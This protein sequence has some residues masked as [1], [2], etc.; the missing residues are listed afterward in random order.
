M[1]SPVPPTTVIPNE[2]GRKAF[3]ALLGGGAGG[4]ALQLSRTSHPFPVEFFL[5]AVVFSGLLLVTSLTLWVAEEIIFPPGEP[6][7]AEQPSDQPLFLR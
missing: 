5:G 2:Y 6:A 4:A 7:E 3:R 1:M